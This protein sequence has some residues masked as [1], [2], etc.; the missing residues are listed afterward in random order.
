MSNAP[1][2]GQPKWNKWRLLAFLLLVGIAWAVRRFESESEDASV[3]RPETATAAEVAADDAPT[4]DL[5]EELSSVSVEQE[6]VDQVEN[7][8]G[9]G[10]AKPKLGQLREVGKKVFVSTAGL[11]YGPGSADGHRLL[12]V[13]QHAED[14]SEKPI[15]GVFE[16]SKEEILAAID[17]AWLLVKEKSKQVKTEEQ[18]GRQVFT[19]DLKRRVGYT[20]GEVGKRK[21]HPACTKIRIVIEDENEV[22]SAYPTDR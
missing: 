5:T 12:H 8:S 1:Q 22:V 2:T 18:G 7:E 17:E 15:H 3:E 9:T 21:N 16:G 6:N 19:I 11:K 14:D 10:N 4:V 20:G 13:M